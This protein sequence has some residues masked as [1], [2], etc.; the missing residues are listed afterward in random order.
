MAKLSAYQRY[1]SRTLKGKMKGKTKAQRKSIFKAA[2][3]GW[4]KGSSKPKAKSKPKSKGSSKPKSGGSMSRKGS[5]LSWVK[6][7]S[8][9]RKIALVAPAAG[10]ALGPGTIQQKVNGA[11][12]DYTGYAMWDGSW[13]W[14]R[15]LR[16][17]TPYVASI[18]VTEGV[19]LVKRLMRSLF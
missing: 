15:L 2:A 18:A 19:D 5:F 1:M 12:A 13:S 11:I 6:I 14:Q 17:W 7:K 4:K 8:W 16:G 3:K 9:I 10:R